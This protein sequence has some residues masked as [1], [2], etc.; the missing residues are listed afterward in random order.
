M[1]IT[2]LKFLNKF[3]LFHI[4]YLTN[5]IVKKVEK[6]DSVELVAN[7]MKLFK[8]FDRIE[9]G[10]EQGIKGRSLALFKKY[11]FA[12]PTKLFDCFTSTFFKALLSNF[13]AINSKK[14]QNNFQEESILLLRNLFEYQSIFVEH[15][16]SSL[17][18]THELPETIE[19]I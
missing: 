5:M 8:G 6:D 7:G 15:L 13:S 11:M 4:N 19:K 2:V 10:D 12:N 3:F 17:F 1:S 14:S 18:L 9:I 16:Q